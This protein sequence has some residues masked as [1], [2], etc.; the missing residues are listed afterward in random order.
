MPWTRIP[1]SAYAAGYDA[2]VQL[3]CS[4]LT[5]TVS[6]QPFY[7]PKLNL[8]ALEALSLLQPPA[9]EVEGQGVQGLLSLNSQRG[10]QLIISEGFSP[11]RT[12]A[13][14]GGD[15]ENVRHNSVNQREQEMSLE[16]DILNTTDAPMIVVA[17][18]IVGELTHSLSTPVKLE[19]YSSGRTTIRLSN[20]PEG[21][22]PIQFRIIDLFRGASREVV[23][24]TLNITGMD[25]SAYLAGRPR[26]G[27]VYYEDLNR[28]NAE[29]ASSLSVDC[30][31]S[32]SAKVVLTAQLH[33][34]FKM[35]RTTY[36]TTSTPNCRLVIK[37]SSDPMHPDIETVCEYFN[38]LNVQTIAQGD[39][40]APLRLEVPLNTKIDGTTQVV[41]LM[42]DLGQATIT[43]ETADNAAQAV[44]QQRVKSHIAQSLKANGSLRL[45][46][47]ISLAGEMPVSTGVQEYSIQQVKVELLQASG[48]NTQPCLA[49]GFALNGNTAALGVLQNFISSADFATVVSGRAIQAIAAFRWRINN[50]PK[51]RLGKPIEG[52]AYTDENGNTIDILIYPNIVQK[53]ILDAQGAVQARIRPMGTYPYGSTSE[54]H[55]LLGGHGDIVVI[56]VLRK[57]N[58]QP[59]PV[60]V[61]NKYM[62]QPQAQNVIFEWPFYLSSVIPPQS[63]PDPNMEDWLQ[64]MRR[65]VNAHLS[66]PFAHK[67]TITLTER[68]ANGIEN[69]LLSRGVISL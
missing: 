56:N 24:G 42:L 41:D 10:A 57:D 67:Q 29:M 58:L 27:I 32:T 69:L 62:A 60:D 36:I 17:Q 52:D 14:Y 23:T 35:E 30:V 51:Q 33:L 18:P 53:D 55:L 66:R 19:P 50:Y 16:L 59:A 65:G 68:R 25:R 64:A 20:I 11:L 38:I 5:Q 47:S 1:L 26:P 8:V 22:H 15:E 45:I 54:D 61:K 48:T 2:V 28:I 63:N 37:S 12:V 7:I 40:T 13:V 21:K 34:K 3:A 4:V 9:A 49:L 46:P 39:I 31:A 43:L 44:F 6:Q